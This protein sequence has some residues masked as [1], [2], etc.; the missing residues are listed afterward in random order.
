M[1]T[2]FKVR[3]VNRDL[4]PA[5]P[6]A[7][8]QARWGDEK[9]QPGLYLPWSVWCAFW[10]WLAAAPNTACEVPPAACPRQKSKNSFDW[11][12]VTALAKH[13]KT[14]RQLF[15]LF[16]WLLLTKQD[17]VWPSSALFLHGYLKTILSNMVKG[18]SISEH[19]IEQLRRAFRDLNFSLVSEHRARARSHTQYIY[20]YHIMMFTLVT[21]IVTVDISWCDIIANEVVNEDAKSNQ[22][23]TNLYH[24]RYVVEL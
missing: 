23:T 1:Q 8:P 12:C 24:A 11:P 14:F 21:A 10:T 22:S 9:K 15:F 4:Q 3:R 19:F 2:D 7:R 16:G 13:A 20:I 18:L 5:T 17:K 6:G